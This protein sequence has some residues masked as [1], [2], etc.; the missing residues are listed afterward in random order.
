MRST[1]GSSQIVFDSAKSQVSTF[2]FTYA[3]PLV[4]NYFHLFTEHLWLPGPSPNMPAATNH[5]ESG[6]EHETKEPLPITTETSLDE[7]HSDD[8]VATTKPLDTKKAFIAWLLLC[9]SVS[10]HSQIYPL[11]D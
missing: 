11:Q 8:E 6:S 10:G 2:F 4:H 9:Y 7:R 3:G 5:A 1:S